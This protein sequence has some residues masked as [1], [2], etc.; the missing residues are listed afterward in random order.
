MAATTSLT[1]AEVSS[2]TMRADGPAPGSVRSIESALGHRLHRVFQVHGGGGDVDPGEPPCCP[3][4]SVPCASRS[5]PSAVHRHT[6]SPGE[7]VRDLAN[8]NS[9]IVK[10]RPIATTREG[11]RVGASGLRI[12]EQMTVLCQPE[13]R[14]RGSWTTRRCVCGR[15]S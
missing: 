10:R 12:H 4:G 8:A 15:D 2:T 3:P 6:H 13:R 1:G 5:R 7:W 14:C 11:R 9:R